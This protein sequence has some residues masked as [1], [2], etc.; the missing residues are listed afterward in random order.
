VLIQAATKWKIDNSV[1]HV[2]PKEV[3]GRSSELAGRHISEACRR[4]INSID[5]LEMELWLV[6]LLKTR[7]VDELT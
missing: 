4:H 7:V 5:T 3:N 6:T 2:Y 1:L